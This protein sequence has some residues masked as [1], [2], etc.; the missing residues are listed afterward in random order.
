MKFAAAALIATVSANQYDFMGED[1]LLVPG[2]RV[3]EVHRVIL[4]HVVVAAVPQMRD[5]QLD[6]L[7]RVLAPHLR[8]VPAAFA[9]VFMERAL[10]D[11]VPPLGHG[12]SAASLPRARPWHGCREARELNG[13]R[14]RIMINLYHANETKRWADR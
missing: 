7:V 10:L 2:H 3:H 5:A 1:E 12:D 6:D 4:G 9:A 14:E 13:S 11:V 8:A